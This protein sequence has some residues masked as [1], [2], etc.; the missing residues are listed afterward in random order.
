MNLSHRAL[1]VTLALALVGAAALPAAAAPAMPLKLSGDGRRLVDQNDVPFLV[2]GDAGWSIIVEL[3]KEEAEQYLEDR[4][5]KGFTLI[6]VN[7][8]EHQFS[9]DPPNNAYGDGPFTTPGDYSS[10]N[11]AYFAHAD[12][13]IAKAE[14]KGLV[15]L[16][17]PSYLGYGG[18]NEGWWQ[19]MLANG[20]TV[21]RDYGRWLG[22]RYESFDNIVWLDGGDY[23][24]P[25]QTL[26][27]ALAEGILETDDRHLHSVHTGPNESAGATY[28]GTAWL[29]VGNTYTYD[30]AVYFYTLQ[31]WNR[32]PFKPFFMIE[33][34]YE[35][36]WIDPP[37]ERIRR[38]AYWPMFT[39]AQGHIMGNFPIWYFGSG[40]Q[41]ALDSPGALDMARLGALFSSIPFHE[42][43][44]DQAHDFLTAGYGTYGG[45]DYVTAALTSD[46]T[47]GGA[48]IPPTGSGSRALTFDLAQMSPDVVIGRWYNPVS[49]LYTA[50]DGSPF[51]TGGPVVIT[52]PGSNGGGDNDWVLLLEDASE[53]TL[54]VDKL[55]LKMDFEDTKPLDGVKFAVRP[56]GLVAAGPDFPLDSVAQVNVAG[57]IETFTFDAKGRAKTL[58]GKA[59][60]KRSKS[61]Q[62]SVRGVLK[63]GMWSAVWTGAGLVNADAKN[64]PVSL[65]LAV[66]IDAEPFEGE[67]DVLF[68]ARENRRGRAKLAN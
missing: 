4:R 10:P 48:Y 25:D 61:G 39:G 27:H 46:G 11:E 40:W 18:G 19:E 1:V 35:E 63:K 16:L 64:L 60:I 54:G 58:L 12:W 30:D 6:M 57:A 50:V 7:L 32:T 2:N 3:T 52:T 49:G 44:P 62:W 5:Q 42:L 59:K 41:D 43:V 20:E 26:V 15:V 13:V 31:D 66:T 45:T 22:T 55:V 68:S 23:S 14:E 33:S 29:D 9:S 37:P 51:A 38:Q 67:A 21:L 47:L 34:H 28:A 8:I 36:N 53:V 65:N 56:L 24:P 17:T